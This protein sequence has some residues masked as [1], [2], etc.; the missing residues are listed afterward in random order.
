MATMWN[1]PALKFPGLANPVGR[2]ALLHYEVALLWRDAGEILAKLPADRVMLLGKFT[3]E[4]LAEY[5]WLSTNRPTYFVPAH[6]VEL[7]AK[8]KYDVEMASL[9]QPI[10]CFH[11][12]FPRGYTIRG[13]RP[14]SVM[15]L[16]ATS[17][18]ANALLDKVTADKTLLASIENNTGL[19]KDPNMKA[20]YTC[21]K[22]LPELFSRLRADMSMPFTIFPFFDNVQCGFMRLESTAR[23]SNVEDIPNT[24]SEALRLGL[25]T[26]A[27]ID[28]EVF[29]SIFKIVIASL[30][31]YTARPETVK[32]YVLP[33]SDRYNHKGEKTQRKIFC[34][35]DPKI[36]RSH[37]SASVE[38]TYSVRPHVR[39]FVYATLRDPKWY[40]NK[41][42][43]PGEPLRIQEREPTIIHPEL[44]EQ[45]NQ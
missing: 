10:D 33:R 14:T 40:R 18:L 22:A 38:P 17:K 1:T 29:N 43:Q 8:S 27:N 4:I 45:V 6:L 5:L 20:V 25:A 42:L 36:V 23:S 28:R 3:L 21:A 41:P 16:R 9:R 26:R 44:F 11:L 13:C 39:G 12:V 34:F 19:F 7:F 15:V 30:C 24:E 2:E 37:T 35:F 31:R 32:D